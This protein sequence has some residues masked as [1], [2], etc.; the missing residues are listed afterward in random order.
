MLKIKTTVI[1]TLVI[2]LIVFSN[3]RVKAQEIRYRPNILLVNGYISHGKKKIEG[4]IVLLYQNDKLVKKVLT[5]KKDQ[6]QFLFFRD[7]KYMIEIIKDGY[8]T[9][10]ILISKE[11]TN[12]SRRKYFYIFRVDLMKIEEFKGLGLT[13]FD[14]PT[15]KIIFNDEDN[16][17]VYDEDYGRIIKAEIEKL[18]K[19]SSSLS[20]SKSIY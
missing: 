20:K 18:K 2:M 13:A 17:Y 7:S 15:A 5:E 14:F 3:E 6:F 8:I 10:K 19:M 9:E 16:E 12:F 1:I 11:S 4:A